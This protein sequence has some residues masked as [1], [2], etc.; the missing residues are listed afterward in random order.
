V[1]DSIKYQEALTVLMGKR[2]AIWRRA[3]N[4]LVLH[5]GQVTRE[6][7][8][9]W[10]EFALHVHCPWRLLKDGSVFVGLADL[11]SPREQTPDFDWKKWHADSGWPDNLLDHQILS[12]L[13]GEDTITRSLENATDHFVVEKVQA[14]EIGD[15][16]LYLSGG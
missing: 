9:S 16:K 15:A 10:G 2:L 3:A 4:M 1:S 8:K 11:Y 13:K 5:F 12:V 7:D 6:A 14:S